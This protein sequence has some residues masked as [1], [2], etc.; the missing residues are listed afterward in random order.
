MKRPAEI[1]VSELP[2]VAFG[3]RAPLWWGVAGLVTVEG[4]VFALLAATYLYLRGGAREWPPPGVA[5]PPLAL[6]TAALL[7]LLLSA[8]PMH[9]ANKAAM[10][11]R[12]RGVQVWLSVATALSVL[13]LVLRAWEFTLLT[14]KWSSHA[15]G[16]VVWTTLGMHTLH[17]L[18]S[19]GEN[20]LLLALLARGPVEDKHLVDI[21]V[22]GFYWY[23]IVLMWVPF[24]VMFYLDPGLFRP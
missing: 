15:Y 22:N 10:A 16:S 8:W 4:I 13:F 20:I 5:E 1:D 9:L 3:H 14:Y 2:T 12:L 21:T 17:M 18:T 11:V 23:F 6:T 19:A 24:Y 7:V